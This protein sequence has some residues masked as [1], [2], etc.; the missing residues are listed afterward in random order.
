M[1]AVVAEAVET[2]LALKTRCSVPRRLRTIT[3]SREG[4]V[5]YAG[6]R[7]PSV[8]TTAPSVGVV[9][10]K[11]VRALLASCL[12]IYR[13]HTTTFLSAHGNIAIRP[14]LSLDGRKMYRTSLLAITES[15]GHPSAP[16]SSMG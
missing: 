12:W 16:Y 3:R 5:A 13:T 10:L 8:R 1:V 14:P 9:C 7:S 2:K 11:W 15:N 4:G 6:D